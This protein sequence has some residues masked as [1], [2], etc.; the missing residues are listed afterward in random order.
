MVWGPPGSQ[1]AAPPFLPNALNLVTRG[2]HPERYLVGQLSRQVARGSGRVVN[3]IRPPRPATRG[4]PPRRGTPV[5][6][7]RRDG[8][9]RTSQPADARCPARRRGPA[10]GRNNVAD[11]RN[12]RYPHPRGV[13]RPAVNRQS[14][15]GATRD[16]SSP[17]GLAAIGAHG[18]CTGYC[19]VVRYRT[20]DS[21]VA[22]VSGGR[23]G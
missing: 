2:V 16:P 18:T 8:A 13:G 10:R 15:C 19:T 6:V 1:T 5:Y 23:D 22:E 7:T 17:T 14:V 4:A 9:W 3:G 12:R 11:V 21:A 20:G